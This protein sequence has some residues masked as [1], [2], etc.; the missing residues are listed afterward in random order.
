ML[1]H[2]NQHFLEGARLTVEVNNL[3]F[4]VP[5]FDTP[6]SRSLTEAL[7]RWKTI[8]HRTFTQYTEVHITLNNILYFL[9]LVWLSFSKDHPATVESPGLGTHRRKNVL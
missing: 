9:H 6:V 1:Y 7:G 8:G 4:A 2:C 3:H 5:L